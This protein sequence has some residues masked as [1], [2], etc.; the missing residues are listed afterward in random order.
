MVM[1][2]RAHQNGVIDGEAARWQRSNDGKAPV[3]DDEVLGGPVAGGGERGNV[4]QG[5]N[6]EKWWR[7]RSSWRGRVGGGA[8]AKIWWLEGSLVG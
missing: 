3:A 2:N 8:A 7:G 6:R 1:G 4:R 5:S